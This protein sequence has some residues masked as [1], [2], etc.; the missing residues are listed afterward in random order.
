MIRQWVEFVLFA[1][2]EVV[3]VGKDKK[4]STT[5]VRWLYTSR[6]PAYDAKAR[7]T[8][9]FPE[10][11]PL[12]WR[13][14]ENAI[15]DDGAR[16]EQLKTEIES[17]LAEIADEKYSEAVHSYL[18]EHPSGIVEARNRVAARIEDVRKHKEQ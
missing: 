1:R 4:A 8:M 7:G 15:R 3:S 18:K 5:G 2:E 16:S 17:M 10:R 11:V 12:S 13:D 14:F 6:K 9:L